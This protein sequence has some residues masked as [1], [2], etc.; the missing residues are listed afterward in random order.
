MTRED[1]IKALKH[2][3]DV[4]SDG[5]ICCNYGDD[6]ILFEMAIEA[7]KQGPILDKIRTEIKEPADRLKDSLYGDG[8]RHAI[9]IIDKYKAESENRDETDD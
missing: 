8:L 7:F 4:M 5:A 3:I 9:E 6:K 1:A 2:K